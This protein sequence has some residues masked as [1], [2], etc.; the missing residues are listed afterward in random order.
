MQAYCSDRRFRIQ[1]R[2]KSCGERFRDQRA[3][4]EHQRLV[5]Q[6]KTKLA[7]GVEIFRQGDREFYCPECQESSEDPHIIQ[8]HFAAQHTGNTTPKT[9]R[10][11]SPMN[12]SPQQERRKRSR[13][14][15]SATPPPSSPIPT[16]ALPSPTP[17]T[18][19]MADIF[20]IDESLV[21]PEGLKNDA[22]NL[23]I[24]ITHHLLVC[25]DCKVCIERK[26]LVN[27]L[28]H[29]HKWYKALPE[30]VEMVIEDYNVVEEFERPE[31]IQLQ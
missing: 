13:L 28:R 23:W 18:N 16:P 21:R 5:H 15:D 26:Q 9:K 1:C 17:S 24:N 3:Q 6:T 14:P 22:A 27:H 11:R 8:S 19:P 7:N 20:T 25:L 31:S 2:T 4:Q 10:A 12:I 29:Q 30:D